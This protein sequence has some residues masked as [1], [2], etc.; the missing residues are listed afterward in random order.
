MRART[1]IFTI[2]A[3]F[4]AIVLID[5][6]GVFDDRG[7]FEVPHGSHTHYVPRNCDPVLPVGNAPTQAPGPG[8]TVSCTGQ[9]VPESVP[10]E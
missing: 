7:Y 8:M 6:I 5:S 4:L 3:V 1:V 9:I 2:I 10:A